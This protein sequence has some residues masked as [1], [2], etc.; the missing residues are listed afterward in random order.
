MCTLIDNIHID[1]SKLSTSTKYGKGYK[2]SKLFF[3]KSFDEF[4]SKQNNDTECIELIKNI[5]VSIFDYIGVFLTYDIDDIVSKIIKKKQ[6]TANV[7]H[8]LDYIESIFNDEFY[9]I[10]D[11]S[12]N[13]K[14]SD[15]IQFTNEDK[16]YYMGLITIETLKILIMN[17]LID[18]YINT[19]SHITN[20]SENILIEAYI[21]CFND[22]IIYSKNLIMK[23]YNTVKTNFSEWND[24]IIS[25]KNIIIQNNILKKN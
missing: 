8:L 6:S 22:R 14:I 1:N 17:R 16:L 11:I 12:I 20:L 18:K 5:R 7:I 24:V 2:D 23:Y 19:S 21:A 13:D 4:I 25:C 10:I 3:I 9:L 15:K